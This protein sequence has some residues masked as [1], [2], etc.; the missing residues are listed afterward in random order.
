[1]RPIA[2]WAYLM[3]MVG[4]ISRGSWSVVR[5]AWF[6]MPS[7]PAILEMPLRCRSD[8][9]IS[10][11]SASIAIAPGTLV[12]GVAAGRGEENATLFVHSTYDN[13]RQSVM[14]GLQRLEGRIIDLLRG[15]H[16]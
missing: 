2:L 7:A 3:A 5:S 6:G 8:V 4:E 16:T 11:F 12:V 13:D 10:L 1:M 15:A 14:E 9:E